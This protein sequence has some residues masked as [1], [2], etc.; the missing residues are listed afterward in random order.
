LPD[1]SSLLGSYLEELYGTL[2]LVFP[3]AGSFVEDWKAEELV[4]IMSFCAILHSR[5][6]QY[7]EGNKMTT[8]PIVLSAAS[9]IM[10]TN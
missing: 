3:V 4:H 7:L 9:V 10:Q 6:R 2:F 1:I 5:H 8:V